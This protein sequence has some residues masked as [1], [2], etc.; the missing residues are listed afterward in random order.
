MSAGP[1]GALLRYRA[2]GWGTRPFPKQDRAGR[3][4]VLA[5]GLDSDREALPIR[6]NAR[7]LGATLAA[8][9]A[10]TYEVDAD[11]QLYLVPAKGRVMLGDLEVGARYGAA[12]TGVSSISIAALEDSEL[13]LVDAA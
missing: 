9:A 12:I 10:L 6:A 3:F 8:G 2:P 5:S 4:V 1:G 11:R 7:V 13:V